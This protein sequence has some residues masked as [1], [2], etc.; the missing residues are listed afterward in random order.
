MKVLI[1][2]SNSLP[3]APTGPV[4]VAGAV[5]KAGHEVQIYERLFA[6]DLEGEL[7]TVLADFHP[8]VVGV[9]IRLVFGDELDAGALLGT[10]HTDFRPHLRQITDIVKQNTAAQIVLGGP[11]FNYYA[12]DWLEYLDLDYGIRSEGEESFPLFLDRLVDGGDIY[13]VPGCVFKTGTS[14]HSISPCLVQDLDGQAFPAYDLLDWPLYAQRKI[15]PAIF[16][17]R[18]CAFSCTYCPYSKLEGKHYRLKSPQR[19]IAET[20]YIL[21]H[22]HTAKVMFCD[23]NFNAP[24]QHAEAICQTIIDENVDFHWGTGDLRPA[25][26]TDDFCLQMEASGCFYANLSVESAS[27]QMLKSMKR[28]YTVM[29]VRE[30][31]EALSRSKIPFGVSLMLGAPGETPETIAE[32]LSVVNDYPIP[33]G[34][35]V[36][37]GVYLWAAY[38]DIVAE[39]RQT[40][41]LKDDN[42]LFSGAVYLSPALPKSY[43]R[44]L[45][46]MLRSK[47][48]YFVQFNKPSA[49]WML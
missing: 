15:T 22:T 38:Q 24:Q 45:P 17:K 27:D 31:L 28:G 2:S 16:T 42:E 46:E 47:G 43:L 11:G 20:R 30:S 7:T 32:T 35:W 37:I 29:Q 21:Q 40:G 33:N 6:D 5:R 10:R 23:N 36:T 44:E 39:A 34:V 3:A 14:Y 19:V 1:I 13:S 26:V 48:N 41:V 8:D 49:S 25:C 4:Y 18:G 12:R 9:S